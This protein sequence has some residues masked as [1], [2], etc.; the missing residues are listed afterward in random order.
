MSTSKTT[1]TP[2]EDTSDRRTVR[3]HLPQP[4]KQFRYAI[5]FMGGGT[6]MLSLFIGIA[7][8][9]LDQT[10]SALETAYRLDHEVV[11][12]MQNS[13][14]GMLVLALGVAVILAVVSIQV[15][16]H[17][18]HRFYGPIIPICRH[19]QELQHGNY[20]SRI[21]L[22]MTDEL[23]EIQDELNALAEILKKKASKSA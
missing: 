1:P 3:G 7:L 2:M 12:A 16:L 5:V 13:V 6:L 17:M 23:T 19:I 15:G 10:A 9:Y 8:Y 22:R 11:K 4:K 14:S 18:S 21:E 20:D